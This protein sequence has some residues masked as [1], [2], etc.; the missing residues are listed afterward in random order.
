MQSEYILSES[1]LEIIEIIR[2]I[3]R[4]AL[5]WKIENIACGD[6]DCKVCVL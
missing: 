5:T 3:K 1:G 4:W 2:D 6:Q